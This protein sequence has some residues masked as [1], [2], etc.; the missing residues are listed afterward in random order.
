MHKSLISL[1]ELIN[2]ATNNEDT[3]C[4]S[5]IA[6]RSQLTPLMKMLTLTQDFISDPTHSGAIQFTR[7]KRLKPSPE[8]THVIA[9]NIRKTVYCKREWRIK[10][11]TT[12]NMAI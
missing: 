12:D 7:S 6:D 2:L 1:N 10:S 8:P 9:A 5:S 4:P 11:D 3:T